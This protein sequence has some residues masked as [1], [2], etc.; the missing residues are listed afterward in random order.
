MKTKENHQQE[1]NIYKYLL[2]NKGGGLSKYEST[3]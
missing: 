3:K 2:S 1:E